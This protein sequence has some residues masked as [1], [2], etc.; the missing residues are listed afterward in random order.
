MP[1]TW[2][3]ALTGFGHTGDQPRGPSTGFAG[4]AEIEWKPISQLTGACVSNKLRA[5]L[6]SP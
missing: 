3:R 6:V 4:R 2:R 5:L 1:A